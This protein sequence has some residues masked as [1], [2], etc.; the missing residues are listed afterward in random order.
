MVG[1]KQFYEISASAV[2]GIR[3]SSG[4]I[5]CGPTQ[6]PPAS[7]DSDVVA[8]PNLIQVLVGLGSGLLKVLH[9]ILHHCQNPNSTTTQLNLT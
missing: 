6:P 1:C 8:E 2:V 9:N 4:A 7:S 3:Q 5:I